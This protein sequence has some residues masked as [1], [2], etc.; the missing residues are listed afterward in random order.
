MTCSFLLMNTLLLQ[1]HFPGRICGKYLHQHV[2]L[3]LI[4]LVYF[5]LFQFSQGTK[6][7]QKLGSYWRTAL[8]NLLSNTVSLFQS[9]FFDH[10]RSI[11]SPHRMFF[12]LVPLQNT[13]VKYLCCNVGCYSVVTWCSL[14]E[15]V[16]AFE[17][18]WEIWLANAA[19]F[20]IC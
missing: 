6:S 20:N 2:V 9:V 7:V 18:H 11:F 4:F 3:L 16:T 19:P 14:S 5:R 17:E 10:F 12:K 13:D 1:H 8:D 15:V